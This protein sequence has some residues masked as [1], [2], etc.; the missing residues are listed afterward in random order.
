MPQD[1]P[2]YLEIVHL[3]PALGDVVDWV[4]EQGSRGQFADRF[5]A[6]LAGYPVEPHYVHPFVGIEAIDVSH[7]LPEISPETPVVL[8]GQWGEVCVQMRADAY[9]AA[10]FGNVIVDPNLTL[11]SADLQS[12]P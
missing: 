12:T 7:H 8:G 11:Y 4:G 9:L 1:N 2:I 10:G 5:I 6:A 3:D